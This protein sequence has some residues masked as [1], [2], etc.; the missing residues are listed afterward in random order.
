M[1]KKQSG[2]FWIV[3]GG[4]IGLAG[5]AIGVLI[6]VFS[7]P[8]SA[9]P[10]RLDD[11]DK[12]VDVAWGF[13][14]EGRPD[15]L[16]GLIHPESPEME[17]VLARLGGLLGSVQEL[18]KTLNETFPDEI[19]QR[20]AEADSSNADDAVDQAR[21]V[22]R[23]G[24]DGQTLASLFADPFAWLRNARDRVTIAYVADDVRAVM[25]DSKPA[26]GVGLT[27]RK[28][29]DGW[30]VVLPMSL[31][32]IRKYMPQN[33]DEWRIVASMVTVVDNA[34]DDL[35]KD[36]RRGRMRNL[37]EVASSAGEKAWAPLVMTAVAYQKA[38]AARKDGR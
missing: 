10:V 11:A 28:Y 20:L 26:F 35:N 5:L 34:V 29:D 12:L 6:S 3:A 37:N 25:I 17:S 22:A 30:R 4:L 18:A 19:A 13:V 9:Q 23:F 2:A 33:L 31:P 16:A 7:G 24:L 27:M 8:R 1:A 36:V 21:R 32:G 14:E 38:M 15:R